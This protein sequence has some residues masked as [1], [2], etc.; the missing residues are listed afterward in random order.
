VSHHHFRQLIEQAM[1]D[2]QWSQGNL[3]VAIGF[4]PNGKTLDA[5]GVRRVITGERPLTAWM[6]HRLIDVLGLNPVE[7]EAA[8]VEDY[9]T[10][11]AVGGSTSDRALVTAG[12]A[13][14][15]QRG[16]TIERWGSRAPQRRWPLR[17]GHNRQEAA[18]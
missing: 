5:T 7:A 1:R 18:A 14:V 8:A 3:A 15:D 13:S 9:R 4:L 6:L 10:F 11:L 2:K 16:R 17:I 12:A